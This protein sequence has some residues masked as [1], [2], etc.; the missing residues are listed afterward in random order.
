[1]STAFGDSTI[2]VAL[3]IARDAN[4]AKAKSVAQSWTG[5]VVTTEYVLL[6]VANHLCGTSDRRGKFRQFLAGLQADPSTQIIEST[7]DIWT[8]GI[9]LYLQRPDKQ[10]SLTDC[11]SFVVMEERGVTDALTADH[12]FEQ[13]GFR[14]LLLS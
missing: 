9:T 5:L 8:R 3:L 14:A 2:Y 11:I 1:M 6:E 4:H 7:H 12:H 10:W 13:G